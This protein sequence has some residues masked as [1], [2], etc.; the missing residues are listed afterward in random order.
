MT[1]LNEPI[2]DVVNGI[3]ELAC[4]LYKV[5]ASLC[6]YHH[7]ALYVLFEAL[8]RELEKVVSDHHNGMPTGM[9]RKPQIA[10]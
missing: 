10:L 9:C 4:Q 6:P 3:H 1:E 8:V 2:E 7:G 5:R